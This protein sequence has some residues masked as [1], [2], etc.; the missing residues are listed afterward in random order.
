MNH[1]ILLFFFTIAAVPRLRLKNNYADIRQENVYYPFFN[2]NGYMA[3]N[4][5]YLIQTLFRVLPSFRGSSLNMVVHHLT[6]EVWTPASLF[7][8]C[9]FFFLLKPK[10]ELDSPQECGWASR[11]PVS[12]YQGTMAS[13]RPRPSLE[14]ALMDLLPRL[15]W[16]MFVDVKQECKDTCVT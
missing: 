13:W 8:P 1:F 7:S 10:S 2:I 5:V 14:Q 11:Q 4:K 9:L 12:P 16:S 15:W 6:D 3:T